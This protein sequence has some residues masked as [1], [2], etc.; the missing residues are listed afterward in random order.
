VR[1]QFILQKGNLLKILVLSDIHGN[2]EALNSVLDASRSELWQEIW[3][4]GDLCGYGPD[5]DACYERLAGNKLTFIPGNH[6]LYIC[7]RLKGQ[8]FSQEARRALILSRSLISGR[9]VKIMED[10]PTSWETKGVLLVHGS[11]EEPTRN[12]ILNDDEALRNSR[13]TRKKC[14]LFG[15]SHIQE[16]YR[17]TRKGVE[18]SRASIGECV[19]YKKE[20]ILINPGSVGQPRD[21]DNRAAWGILDTKRKE[22]TF[23]RTS[24]DFRVTQKKMRSAG[25]SDFLIHRLEGGR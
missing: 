20:K 18:S 25:F 6:D 16:Y 5:P 21:R 2:L 14:I 4:L 11:P 15:H 12:Y 8:Y 3:F 9:L 10:L 13:L 1:Q 22:F 19:S 7:G 24:Y 17:I 23:Y